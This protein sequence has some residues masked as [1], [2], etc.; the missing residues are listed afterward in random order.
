MTQL[1]DIIEKWS[2]AGKEDQARDLFDALGEAGELTGDV[3]NV[4]VDSQGEQLGIAVC[5]W[6]QVPVAL[7]KFAPVK[8]ES[9][10]P[11]MVRVYS[12]VYGFFAGNLEFANLTPRG[13]AIVTAINGREN[14]DLFEEAEELGEAAGVEDAGEILGRP[15]KPHWDAFEKRMAEIVYTRVVI[16]IT[17]P[18]ADM[19]EENVKAAAKAAGINF[20]SLKVKMPNK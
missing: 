10:L 20:L 5:D 6:T 15:F 3:F 17:N 7:V 12:E 14:N 9:D 4:R 16:E 1:K 18:P 19:T 8:D 13:K 2:Q 11:R